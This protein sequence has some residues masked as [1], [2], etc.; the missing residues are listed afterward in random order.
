MMNVREYYVEVVQPSV[1]IFEEKETAL[2]S[3]ENERTRRQAMAAGVGAAVA[4]ANLVDYRFKEMEANGSTTGL[5]RPSQL[6][7]Q[8][9]PFCPLMDVINDVAD[10]HKHCQ[11]NDQ[12][13][14]VFSATSVA[15]M[16]VDWDKFHWDEAS[17]GGHQVCV[18]KRDGTEVR[19]LMVVI[20]QVCRYWEG[21]LGLA[22][23]PRASPDAG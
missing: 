15:P 14:Y 12:S 13:R 22:T 1:E 8:L 16:S 4:V 7:E 10:A 20:Q 3:A 11:L 19:P 2:A 5:T 21:E 23:S 17:W 18:E 6:R 9:A